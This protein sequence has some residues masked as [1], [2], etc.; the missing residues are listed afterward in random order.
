MHFRTTSY[1]SGRSETEVSLK[2]Y[3]YCGKERD[4]QTGFYYYGMRYYAGW[5]CRFV[6]VDPMADEYP[7][8]TPYAYCANNPLKYIDPTGENFGDYY[9]L[10]GIWLGSDGKNDDKAYTAESK[11]EDGS[12]KNAKE[13]S[14]GNTE[15][16]D[17]ATWVH[18]ESGGSSEVITDRTQNAGEASKTSDARVADYYANAINNIAD[19]YGDFYKG[20]QKR[21][22][23]KIGNRIVNTNEGYFSGTGIGGNKS[24]KAFA[25]ARQQGMESL[26]KLSGA[27]TSI[28]AVIKS[29]SGG[30][31]PTG[32]ARAW[33]GV[34][35]AK[36]YVN[37]TQ[38]SKNKAVF[39]FSFSSGKGKHFH[40][41]YKNK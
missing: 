41:F 37:N 18:G 3:K 36:K 15:L 1:R 20:V 9:T 40:S 14:I 17:R 33:L 39:Q 16:L 6:S 32:G 2:R 23:K 30:T 10:E 25:N 4:E 5:L 31:D 29:V 26:M 38:N 8:L 27:T 13:L 12:F 35:D 21:M 28:S 34:S 22:S 24:S 7:G 11:N 19:N